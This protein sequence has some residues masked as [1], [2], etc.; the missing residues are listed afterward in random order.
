MYRSVSTMKLDW[1]GYLL[2]VVSFLAFS[3]GKLSF[4]ECDLSCSIHFDPLPLMC[5]ILTYM[6]HHSST[7]MNITPIK[8]DISYIDTKTYIICSYTYYIIPY[9]E[10]FGHAKS[11]AYSFSS[12]PGGGGKRDLS[13]IAGRRLR[14]DIDPRGEMGPGGRALFHPHLEDHPI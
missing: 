8:V 12:G 3:H 1:F 6:Y 7:I 14:G 13:D 4:W 10:W 11:T 9:F 5:D 2:L